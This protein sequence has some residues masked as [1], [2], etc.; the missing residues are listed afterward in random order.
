MAT[1]KKRKATKVPYVR[2]TPDEL[3][4]LIASIAQVLPPGGATSEELQLQLGV[5]TPEGRV[6]PL[7]LPLR[8]GVRYDVFKRKGVARATRYTLAMPTA[9]SAKVVMQKVFGA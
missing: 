7:E 2:R 9:R 3:A 6:G 4:L 5:E 1:K 8:L